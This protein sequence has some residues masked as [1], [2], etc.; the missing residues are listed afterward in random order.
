MRNMQI[1]LLPL[2]QPRNDNS[3]REK[4]K[5]QNRLIGEDG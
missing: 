5:K 4:K 1:N 3:V 2:E